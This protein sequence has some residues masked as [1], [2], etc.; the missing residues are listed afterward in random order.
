MK[1]RSVELYVHIYN[2]G[3]RIAKRTDVMTQSTLTRGSH[4]AIPCSL[5]EIS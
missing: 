3:P 1:T 5:L 2:G 4:H